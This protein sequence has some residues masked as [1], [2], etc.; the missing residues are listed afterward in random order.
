MSF[1]GSR[2]FFR[3]ESPP[4]P[5]LPCCGLHCREVSAC[6][7]WEWGS[8]A[9]YLLRGAQPT[10]SA[11]N[12]RQ[13]KIIPLQQGRWIADSFT[14]QM[15]SSQTSLSASADIAVMSTGYAIR[16]HFNR[17][18]FLLRLLPACVAPLSYFNTLIHP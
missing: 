10:G 2:A 15:C 7:N 17:S 1:V 3:N 6:P 14:R 18:F 4:H 12:Q 13:A 16:K 8:N 5:H 11:Q 9:L